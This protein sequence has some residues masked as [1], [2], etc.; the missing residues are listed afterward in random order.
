MPS[1]AQASYLLTLGVASAAGI[2][3]WLFVAPMAVDNEK[4]QDILVT[5]FSILA[6]F[7]IAIMTLLGEQSLRLGGWSRTRIDADAN[8]RRLD[9]Q[10][11][12][13]WL[14][15]LT[16]SVILAGRLLHAKHAQLSAEMQRAGFAMASAALVISFVL[17]AALRGAQVAR[18]DAAVE[19]ERDKSTRL[20]RS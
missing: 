17:P 12:L 15:L 16:L 6:G 14:Y 10:Q 13:F 9:R 11:Q 8:R 4:A 19:K 5:L 7:I 3:S 18:M 20:G 1:R 2:L